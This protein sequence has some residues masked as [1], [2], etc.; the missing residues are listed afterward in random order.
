[1]VGKWMQAL[2]VAGVLLAGR[3]G[4][5]APLAIGGQ[6]APFSLQ[7]QR[8]QAQRMDEA[9]R[10]LL[11]SRDRSLTA[12]AF[13]VLD[14]K[15]PGFLADHHAL[16]IL[17][18]S[19]MPGFITWSVARPRMRRHAF[20]ILLDAG[21]TVS[22]SLP[23]QGRMLTLVYLNRLAVERIAYLSTA[24]ELEQALAALNP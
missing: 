21:P 2:T 8:D 12:M 23:T 1:M 14:G 13:Q 22:R 7:D 10:L 24:A 11:F 16:V 3:T 5:A 20:P 6:V 18:I 19:A 15:A 9:T 4:A 17:D